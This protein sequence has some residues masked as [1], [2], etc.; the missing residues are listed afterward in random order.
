MSEEM[1]KRVD[2]SWKEQVEREKQQP[3]PAGA[4]AGAGGPAIQ[5]GPAPA[6]TPQQP[7]ASGGPA[8]AEEG[9]P[10]ARF[11]LF[12]SGLA[13]EALM[14]LGDAPHPVTRKQSM[15]PKQARYLIDVLGILEEKTRGNLSVDEERLLKDVLYQLRTRYLTKFGG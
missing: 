9:L 5:P 13:M 3:P 2:E 15:N 8:K 1:Q 6:A 10:E 7:L 12:V 14:A 11:G 4:P